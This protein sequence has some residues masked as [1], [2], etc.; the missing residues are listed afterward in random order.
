M[1]GAIAGD[2]IGSIFE[3]VVPRDGVGLIVELKGAGY[4]N[5]R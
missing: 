1:L 3:C 5:L 4:P 2:S